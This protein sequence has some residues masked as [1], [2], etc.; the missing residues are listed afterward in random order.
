M[1]GRSHTNSLTLP[2][3]LKRPQ[4]TLAEDRSCPFIAHDGYRLT[5]MHPLN[6]RGFRAFQSVGY[7]NTLNGHSTFFASLG[8]LPSSLYKLA[9]DTGEIVHLLHSLLF[10]FVFPVFA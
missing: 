7:N 9:D 6:K 8:I 1:R 2:K 10:V 4:D 5:W 3:G